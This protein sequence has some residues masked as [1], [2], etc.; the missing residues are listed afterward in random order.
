MKLG[1]FHATI[2]HRLH[3]AKE[4]KQW[5]CNGNPIL[6]E[7]HAKFIKSIFKGMASCNPPP[8]PPKKKQKK[9]K[10]E[11]EE[12]KRKKTYPLVLYVFSPIG[13]GDTLPD[14]TR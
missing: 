14:L 10:K 3:G 1:H 12:R 2:P 11:K 13:P 4:V 6:A 7:E 5:Y 9:K 8:P